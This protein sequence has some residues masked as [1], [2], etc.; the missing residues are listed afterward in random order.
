MM[1][2]TI[3]F[4]EYEENTEKYAG[5]KV[6]LDTFNGREEVTGHRNGWAVCGKANAGFGL[7][8]MMSS[9]D[10]LVVIV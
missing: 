4:K 10:K 7:S 1:E 6:Y 2:H 8:F 9:T 5:S 3:N